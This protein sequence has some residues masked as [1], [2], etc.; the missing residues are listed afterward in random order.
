NYIN[1]TMNEDVDIEHLVGRYIHVQNN[2]DMNAVYKIESAESLGNNQVRIG[3]GDVTLINR[4]VNSQNPDSGYVYDIA[5]AQSFTIPLSSEYDASPVFNIVTKKNVDAGSQI[6]VKVSAQ[7]PLDLPL[8]YKSVTLPRGASFDETTQIINWVPGQEQVGNNLI[9]IKAVDSEG[10]ESVLDFIVRVLSST[11]KS[12]GT[13]TE[14]SGTI[15]TPGGSNGNDGSNG[16]VKLP[17]IQPDIPP[18]SNNA[19]IDL[20][21]FDWAKDSINKLA[22]D[23]IIK[24]TSPTTFSPATNIKRADFVILL[25]RT[26]G[27]KVLESIEQFSDI[28]S[29]DYFASEISTARAA[30]IVSGTGNNAFAPQLPITRQDMMVILYNTLIHVGVDIEK[31]EKCDYPDFEQVSGYAK[32]AVA[33]LTTNGIVRGSGGFINPN[34]NTTRAEVAVLLLRILALSR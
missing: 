19:F 13:S 27:L 22:E 3:I 1:V 11:Y 26:F 2:K 17:V 29:D 24:G 18:V 6:R 21:G 14:N 34:N 15:G 23:E 12:D 28:N 9:S 25:V 10:R 7:S 30:G 16:D 32:E 31:A 4:Y 20:E 8:T 5:N 33:T